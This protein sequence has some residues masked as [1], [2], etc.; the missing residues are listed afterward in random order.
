MSCL[1]NG[2]VLLLNAINNA[3]T[4]QNGIMERRNRLFHQ[5]GKRLMSISS[6][7]ITANVEE[8]RKWTLK[9]NGRI[10]F[11]YAYFAVITIR[12]I[13]FF[14]CLSFSDR[15]F[16]VAYFKYDPTYDF[17]H[18]MG[19]LD[20]NLALMFLLLTPVL[21]YLDYLTSFTRRYRC[22]LYSYDLL[23]TNR[24]KFYLLN[25][26]VDTWRKLFL[27]LGKKADCMK[28]KQEI[29]LK[30]RTLPSLGPLDHCIRVHS[31]ALATALDLMVAMTTMLLATFCPLALG[32][33]SLTSV[34][35]RVSVARKRLAT[36]DG[37]L[38]LYCLWHTFK[39]SLYLA[40]WIITLFSVQLA[41]QRLFDWQLACLL[42]NAKKEQTRLKVAGKK[43]KKVLL[44]KNRRA[45][46]QKQ[47]LLSTFLSTVYLRGHRQLVD[48]MLTQNRQLTSRLLFFGLISLFGFTLYSFSMFTLK[49]HLKNSFVSLS[50][51]L[52]LVIIFIGIRPLIAATRLMHRPAKELLYSS[53]QC[54]S[55]CES[56]E[57]EHHS[58]YK[59]ESRRR[60]GS[61][62]VELH[63]K[64]KLATYYEVLNSGEKFAFSAGALGKITPSALFQ[65]TVVVC[66]FIQ[67]F[68]NFFK[69]IF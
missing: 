1:K 10:L 18:Q 49:D 57:S 68:Y 9:L 12:T 63:L 40:H 62:L 45:V 55:W 14:I 35:K 56:C 46:C 48:D 32:L 28:R 15:F 6:D 17:L 19:M 64:V 65:V 25:P 51:L 26:Q 60:Y 54:L 47:L 39:I 7:Y 67:L 22:Y 13:I 41:Q 16:A 2:S 33:F 66:L 36:V 52:V 58:S 61:R 43:W 27:L 42:V 23:V 24:K 29:R 34:W 69:K 3:T 8:D 5:L 11:T 59:I 38:G 50:S 44:Y 21:P 31:V 30:W 4:P 37:C 20:R 53:L